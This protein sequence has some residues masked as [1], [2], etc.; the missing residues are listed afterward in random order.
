MTVVNGLNNSTYKHS[1]ALASFSQGKLGALLDKRTGGAPSMH[2]AIHFFKV[3][4]FFDSAFYHDDNLMIT[5]CVLR[6][7]MLTWAQN[8][9]TKAH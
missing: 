2:I 5:T 7:L 4:K 9:N 6:L 8:S 1:A 3:H